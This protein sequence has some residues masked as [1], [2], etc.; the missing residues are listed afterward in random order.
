MRLEAHLPYRRFP[1]AKQSIAGPLAREVDLHVIANAHDVDAR[2]PEVDAEP[3]R[4]GCRRPRCARTPTCLSL[5]MRMTWMQHELISEELEAHVTADSHD[6]T[7]APL[8]ETAIEL[9]E[10]TEDVPKPA[11]MY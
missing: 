4:C 9:D 2:G 11:R 3:A 1:R 6:A 5:Q 7:A 8:D 10:T